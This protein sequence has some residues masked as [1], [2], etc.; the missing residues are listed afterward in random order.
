MQ[1]YFA[2]TFGNPAL[3]TKIPNGFFAPNT[4]RVGA[5]PLVDSPVAPGMTSYSQLR[6]ARASAVK[7]AV[8]ASPIAPTISVGRGHMRAGGGYRG[9]GGKK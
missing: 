5:R 7:A 6:D 8:R 9:G 3:V 1:P 4:L 2:G